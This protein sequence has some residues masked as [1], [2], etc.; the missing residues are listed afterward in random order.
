MKITGIPGKSVT[1]KFLMQMDV[2][3]KRSQ[4]REAEKVMS[5]PGF[6]ENVRTENGAEI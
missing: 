4:K 6:S 3:S 1:A 2:R 5:E